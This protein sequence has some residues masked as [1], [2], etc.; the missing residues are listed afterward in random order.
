M[1][2]FLEIDISE[3]KYERKRTKDGKKIDEKKWRW[4]AG[5]S[6]DVVDVR[7]RIEELE[8]RDRNGNEKKKTERDGENTENEIRNRK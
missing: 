1:K 8:W 2:Y 6:T 7:E 5:K 3:W 4:E